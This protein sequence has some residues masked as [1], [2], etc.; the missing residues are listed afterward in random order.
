MAGGQ[1]IGIISLSVI[2]G[3]LIG[4][5]NFLAVAFTNYLSQLVSKCEEGVRQECALSLVDPNRLANVFPKFA[6]GAFDYVQ[7]S[8]HLLIHPSCTFARI[9]APAE[10]PIYRSLKAP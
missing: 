5:R 4:S 10:C 6:S 3:A 9:C 1:S 2:Q 7:I 8:W